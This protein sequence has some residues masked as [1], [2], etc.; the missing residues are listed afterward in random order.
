MAKMPSS[1]G[2]YTITAQIAKGGMGEVFK[3]E[4]PTLKGSLVIKR[5]TMRGNKNIRDRFLREARIMIDFKSEYI[6]DVYDHF[7]EGSSY[8]IVQEFIDGMSLDALIERERYL[9]EPVALRI[10]LYACRAVRYAHAKGVIHRDIK[11][12]N[13]LVSREGRVKLVDFG[14]ASMRSAETTDESLTREGMTLGTPSY[15]APEQ[16][17]STRDVDERADIYSL[18]VMLY[19]SVTGKKPFPGSINPETLRLIQIGKCPRPRKLNP[20]VSRFAQ[21]LIRRCMHPKKKRRFGDLNRIIR[22]VER[23]LGVRPS[24]HDPHESAAVLSAYVAER[25]YVEPRRPI[26]K[27]VAL[28]AT[29][30]AVAITAFIG[31][32]VTHGYH[33]ALIDPDGHGAFNLEIDVTG[34]PR[35]PSDLFIEARLYTGTSS[36]PTRLPVTAVNAEPGLS[37]GGFLSDALGFAAGSAESAPVTRSDATRFRTLRRYLPVGRHRIEVRIESRVY[38]ESFYVHSRASGG[39]GAAEPTRIA[40][41]HRAPDP[42]PVSL[43]AT[44]RDQ[45]SGRDI[46]S[47]TRIR[48]RRGATWVHHHPDVPIPRT[49]DGLYEIAITR[50]GYYDKTYTL[51]IDTAQRHARLAAGLVPRPG[52]LELRSTVE[53]VSVSLEG[54]S[55]YIEGGRAAELGSLE[56]LGI[57]SPMKIVLPPRT[58]MLRLDAGRRGTIELPVQIL[59]GYTQV[60]NVSVDDDNTVRVVPGPRVRTPELG[61]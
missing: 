50:D 38:V 32:G 17:H 60:L 23:R 29:V 8:H 61:E 37:F 20:H 35:P 12:G 57:E 4:H 36:V 25:P 26:S 18:G 24:L 48:V 54:S 30:F 43:T 15:M 9:P 51:E 52:A 13:I 21:R 31:F 33:R 1:I 56:R 49:R 3:A 14:I 16:F 39:F 5:L 46:T 7:R 40:V 10:F 55:R 34:E 47:G 42:G 6:V 59:G 27:R 28:A 53:R 11:P 41:F 2:K 45:V 44:V 19:E 58:Y 22:L